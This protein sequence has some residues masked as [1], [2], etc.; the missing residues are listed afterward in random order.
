MGCSAGALVKRLRKARRHNKDSVGEIDAFIDD[1]RTIKSLETEMTIRN[2]SWG[3]GYENSIK[4][5]GLSDRAL[6]HLRQFGE[7]RA[8]SLQQACNLWEKADIAL[9][10]LDEFEDV[11]F[12]FYC[13]H[14][15]DILYQVKKNLFE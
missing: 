14:H 5:L 15:G 12:E 10:M 8:V 3:D 2:L 4:N 6:K 7:S 13:E 9:K 11:W 1:I